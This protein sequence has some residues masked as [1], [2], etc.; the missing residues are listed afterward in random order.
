[1]TQSQL[2]ITTPARWRSQL[3]AVLGLLVT[4]NVTSP[5]NAFVWVNKRCSSTEAEAAYTR[6]PG[7]VKQ[8]GWMSASTGPFGW[9]GT[10]CSEQPA[11]LYSLP[12]LVM[13]SFGP[14][15]PGRF[16]TQSWSKNYS[17]SPIRVLKIVYKFPSPNCTLV[18][19]RRYRGTEPGVCRLCCDY[20]FASLW[21]CTFPFS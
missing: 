8:T 10:L 7:M 19:T 21:T 5:V 1:M 4:K 15:S 18:T 9:V 12:L 11:Y 2:E 17:P 13:H 20:M 14:R 16:P 3:F 6:V